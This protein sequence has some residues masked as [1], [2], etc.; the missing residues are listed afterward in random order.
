[1]KNHSNIFCFSIL[2]LGL[3]GC[4]L[5]ASEMQKTVSLINQEFDNIADT[6]QSIQ[7]ADSANAAAGKLDKQYAELTNLFKTLLELMN[8]KPDD[9]LN[10]ST[11]AT[12]QKNYARIIKECDRI[13]NIKGLPVNLCPINRKRV[14]ELCITVFE[15]QQFS[16]NNRHKVNKEYFDILKRSLQQYGYEKL[17]KIQLANLTPGLMLN[18]Y[19]KLHEVAPSLQAFLMPM[20]DMHLLFV[21]P[22]P[23]FKKFLA[24]FDI[25]AVTFKDELQQCIK[26]EVDRRKLGARANTD[27]EEEELLS[28]EIQKKGEV[29]RQQFDAVSA[30][31][32]Q[33]MAANVK[34]FQADANMRFENVQRGMKEQQD[35]MEQFR[36]KFKDDT[37]AKRLGLTERNQD[38]KDPDSNDPDYYEKL[39][40]RLS[41][42]N[43]I[44]QNEAISILV[45]TRPDQVA[46][47]DTRKK[48]ARAFKELA[49]NDSIGQQ[50]KAVKGLAIWGGKFSVPILL[51]LLRESNPLLQKDVIKALG[52]LKD[53]KSAA[54][55]V[56]LLSDFQLHDAAYNAL[57]D[58]GSAAEDA[59]IEATRSQSPEVIVAAITLL[60][61]VGS[62]KSLKALRALQSSRN[63]QIRTA[64][65]TAMA[66][67]V[68]RQKESKE[69]SR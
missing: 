47:A 8:N 58:M 10:D 54:P 33:E 52:E 18:V 22:V 48:I 41:S 68:A 39:A 37:A 11:F 21:E 69:S 23:D 63:L 38:V 43:L 4:G 17:V 45:R 46:S 3:F 12:I 44:E 64:M 42:D 30:R 19:H 29:L 40:E 66:K 59:L 7:D 28:E 31:A 36:Q 32:K 24:T 51:K 1:V 53:P 67:V 9:N 60:G 56:D 55:L 5:P 49:E 26:I 6:M 14:Y 34:D 25:G 16:E 13:D 61:E 50:Q 20:G 15:L 27:A 35:R 65:K 2:I 57:Q 62:D